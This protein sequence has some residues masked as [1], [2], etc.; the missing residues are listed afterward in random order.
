MFFKIKIISVYDNNKKVEIQ[1]AF[2][3]NNIKYSLKTKPLHRQNT[4][5]F[6]KLGPL[7]NHKIQFVHSFYVDK[8]D[9]EKALLLIKNLLYS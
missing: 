3:V 9:K 2:A 4:Y 5:D 8:K 6:A 1:D 7:A